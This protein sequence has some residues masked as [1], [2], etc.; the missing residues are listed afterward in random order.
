MDIARVL[1]EQDEKSR[2][3]QLVFKVSAWFQSKDGVC[4][5]ENRYKIFGWE[6]V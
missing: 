3:A 1:V 2:L 5:F 4:R 6:F